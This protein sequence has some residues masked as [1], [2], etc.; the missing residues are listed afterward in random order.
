MGIIIEPNL[1]VE[2]IKLEV[3]DNDEKAAE[4]IL[5]AWGPTM[6]VIKI[7][8]YVLGAGEIQE[9]NLKIYYNSIPKFSLIVEDSTYKIRK[10][11]KKEIIDKIIIFIGYKDWYLKFNGI[12]LN[13]P[14]DTG[15]KNIYIIGEFFN[16]KLYDSIQK[17]YN[18]KN[19]SDIFKDICSITKMGLFTY[20][21][22]SL[23][24]TLKNCLNTNK[25]HL[26]FFIET[27]EK[28][29]N[30][31]WC[32]DTFGYFHVSDIE[33]LRKQ[34]VDKFK[35]FEGKVNDAEKDII[36]TTNVYD[37]T[38]FNEN[39]SDKKNTK[40]LASGY[41]ITSNI[42]KTH[43]YN[44]NKYDV[45]TDTNNKIL[46]SKDIGIGNQTE[47]TFSRFLNSYFP[48]Y[49]DRINKDIGG[50][51]I[52]LTM[53]NLIYEITP[54]SIVNLEVYLPKDSKEVNNKLDEENSGKK[55]V[56]GYEYEFFAKSKNNTNPTIIQKLDLI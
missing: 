14:S 12:I 13:I 23:T 30:N 10:T 38:G 18:D 11:L 26:D 52:S 56:I 5:D 53:K 8:D 51:T 37:N 47:N 42:G 3:N 28:Y 22:N 35:I 25:K 24:N 54:F 20:S 44:N 1:F 17:S 21:N 15:D 9:F 49:N 40:F 45:K 36:I 55:I 31:I 19:V 4:Q 6:P 29:T 33:T 7:N 27:V 50:K 39:D 34:P 41:T 46:V 48:Y 32:L 43:V 16:D 2:D